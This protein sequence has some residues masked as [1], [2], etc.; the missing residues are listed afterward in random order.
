MSTEKYTLKV[1]HE[2]D[3]IWAEVLELPGCFAS[4]SDMD[5]LKEALEEALTLYLSESPGQLQVTITSL[6]SQRITRKAH[7]QAELVAA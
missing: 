3:T 7:V 1:H 4:G 5:E 6:E 2:G